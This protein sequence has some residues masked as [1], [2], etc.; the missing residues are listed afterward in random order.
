M[1]AAQLT[2]GVDAHEKTF[3]QDKSVQGEGVFFAHWVKNNLSRGI[4]LGQNPWWL[5]QQHV[6]QL[7]ISF[8]RFRVKNA[9]SMEYS[10]A[11]GG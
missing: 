4:I 10:P 1:H 5:A 11:S 9:F 6:Q 8:F 7:P 2:D 3:C